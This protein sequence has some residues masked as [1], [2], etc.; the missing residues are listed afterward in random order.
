MTSTLRS[1][2]I[3]LQ[4]NS[5][6]LLYIKTDCSTGII[7]FNNILIYIY[8]ITQQYTTIIIYIYIHIQSYTHTIHSAHHHDIGFFHMLDHTLLNII[9]QCTI[10][11]TS[12]SSPWG[13]PKTRDRLPFVSK[14]PLPVLVI[15]QMLQDSGREFLRWFFTVVLN[16]KPSKPC[17][18]YGS[19]FFD[20]SYKVLYIIWYNLLIIIWSYII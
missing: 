6:N 7:H 4:W 1:D 8:I 16:T 2:V 5:R 15:N 3:G 12:S 20:L 18:L 17:Y 14:E 19:I 13:S 10:K 9:K 11:L